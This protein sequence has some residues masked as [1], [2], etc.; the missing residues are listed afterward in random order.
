MREILTLTWQYKTLADLEDKIRQHLNDQASMREET[1]A[2]AAAAEKTNDEVDEALLPLEDKHIDDLDKLHEDR[3]SFE[4]QMLAKVEEHSVRLQQTIARQEAEKKSLD[5]LRSEYDEVVKQREDRADKVKALERLL[6][7]RNKNLIS[8]RAELDKIVKDRRQKKLEWDRLQELRANRKKAY[9]EAR[10]S[11]D[12]YAAQ[13]KARRAQFDALFVGNTSINAERLRVLRVAGNFHHG[14]KDRELEAARLEQMSWQPADSQLQAIFMPD[15]RVL[16]SDVDSPKDAEETRV[17]LEPEIRRLLDE[18]FE[19]YPA[20]EEMEFSLAKA[21]IW[22][23]MPFL[24]MVQYEDFVKRAYEEQYAK[25]QERMKTITPRRLFKATT[26]ELLAYG[27]A[28]RELEGKGQQ[29]L[30]AMLKDNNGTGVTDLERE[31]M[32]AADGFDTHQ[33]QE[34]H[35]A[36]EK[37]RADAEAAEERTR[38]GERKKEQFEIEADAGAAGADEIAGIAECSDEESGSNSGEDGRDLEPD[39]AERDR[40]SDQGE[41]S[42]RGED[43]DA[44]EQEHDSSDGQDS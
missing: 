26:R 36:R 3:E 4:E 5:A 33:A 23:R 43:D 22:T 1:A 28:P 34:E 12:T 6:N 32:Q 14:N 2:A 7:E 17:R 15:G 8:A 11:F 35:V 10:E 31:I 41:D 29:E 9:L 27:Y 39:D 24:H 19:D 18:F 37:A 40:P 30:T 21:H 42:D 44:S 20:S 25:F 16:K 38:E 13:S